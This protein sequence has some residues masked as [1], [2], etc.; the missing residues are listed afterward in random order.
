[1]SPVR[2]H[3]IVFT[4]RY[5]V[6][7]DNPLRIFLTIP[8]FFAIVTGILLKVY[9]RFRLFLV[10]IILLCCSLELIILYYTY[11]YFAIDIIHNLYMYIYHFLCLFFYMYTFSQLCVILMP[12]Q[13]SFFSL[14]VIAKLIRQ[15]KKKGFKYDY[16]SKTKRIYVQIP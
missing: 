7:V 5:W 15:S 8:H 14:P 16:Y 6:Q 10:V 1:M 12:Y 2:F 11:I 9:R 3:L 13:E 4:L